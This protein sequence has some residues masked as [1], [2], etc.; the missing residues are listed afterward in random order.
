[1]IVETSSKSPLS[2]PGLV[3]KHGRHNLCYSPLA[4]SGTI[5]GIK[6]EH[7]ETHCQYR[8]Q[9]GRQHRSDLNSTFPCKKCVFLTGIEPTEK[10]HLVHSQPPNPLDHAGLDNVDSNMLCQILKTYIKHIRRK[11]SAS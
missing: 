7:M 10:M 8:Y 11:H 1:M 5:R 4:T 9:L 3:F 6:A 2:L